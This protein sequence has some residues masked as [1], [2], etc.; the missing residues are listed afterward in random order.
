MPHPQQRQGVLPRPL[1]R[2]SSP[3]GITFPWYSL[4]AGGLPWW[5]WRGRLGHRMGM[6]M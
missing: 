5:H 3:G 4:V 2:P 1:Q 6:M